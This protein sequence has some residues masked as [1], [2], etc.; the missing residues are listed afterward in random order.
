MIVSAE[1]RDVVYVEHAQGGE[2]RLG[3]DVLLTD[4]QLGGV[5]SY[6]AQISLEPGCSLGVHKHEGDSELYFI[7]EGTGL[8]SDN[9]VETQ[10]GP[11]DVT[12][13][14][15]GGE[16]GMMNNGTETLKFVAVIQ[17]SA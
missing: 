14:P 6:V 1:S 9:G 15:D 10:V 5:C 12:F 13:C 3:R 16:H 17:K 8:Y 7:T 4:D 2:G 11:G